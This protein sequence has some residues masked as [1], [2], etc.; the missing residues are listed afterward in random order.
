MYLAY[1]HLVA[2]LFTAESEAQSGKYSVQLTL[3]YMTSVHS[4]FVLPILCLYSVHTNFCFYSVSS[5]NGVFM[6]A[7]RL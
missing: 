6:H 2:Q 7:Y 5:C 1:T 3:L 4:I